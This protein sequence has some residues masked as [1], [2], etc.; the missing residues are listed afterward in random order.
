VTD[1]SISRLLLFEYGLNCQIL[2]KSA[3][4]NQNIRVYFKLGPAYKLNCDYLKLFINVFRFF[5]KMTLLHI[6]L[7]IIV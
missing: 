6:A 1:C 3:K 5:S 2:N 7:N 4:P